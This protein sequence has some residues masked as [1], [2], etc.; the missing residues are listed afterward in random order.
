MAIYANVKIHNLN[1][2]LKKNVSFHGFIVDV[3]VAVQAFFD[4]VVDVSVV[5][6]FIVVVIKKQVIFLL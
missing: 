4:V 2:T 6:I 1:W 5:D 3:V